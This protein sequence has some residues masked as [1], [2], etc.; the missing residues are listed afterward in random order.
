MKSQPA[1]MV[2]PPARLAP[3]TCSPSDR[4]GFSFFISS[5]EIFRIFSGISLIFCAI[6]ERKRSFRIASILPGKS[7]GSLC[8]A[9]ACITHRLYEKPVWKRSAGSD[10]LNE[11]RTRGGVSSA[12]ESMQVRSGEVCHW[13]YEVGNRLRKKALASSIRRS[14]PPAARGFVQLFPPIRLSPLTATWMPDR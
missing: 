14:F 7:C 9:E 10:S 5:S 12:P 13:R 2:P 8:N 1:N 11:R 4:A 6:F 3:R